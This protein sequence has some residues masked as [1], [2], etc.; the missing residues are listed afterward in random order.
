M[1]AVVKRVVIMIQENHTID[2]YFRGLAP[3]G[4]AVASDWSLPAKGG[5]RVELRRSRG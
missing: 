5:C 3:V 1:A 4:A 2:N